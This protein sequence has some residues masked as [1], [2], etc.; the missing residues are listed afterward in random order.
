MTPAIPIVDVT[1]LFDAAPHARQAPDR[2][3]AAAARDIG[4]VC[5]CGLPPEAAPD[6]AARARLLA[7]FGLE[8]A[9][10]RRLYRRKFAPE[11]PNIYRGWF[12]LQPGNLTAKEGIDIGG[13]LVHGSAIAVRGD[14]LREPSPLPDERCLP[15]WRAAAAAYYRAMELVAQA[16]MCSLA[17]GL[18]LRSDYF[19]DSFRCG[20]STL[21]LIRYPPRDPAELATVQDPAVWAEVDGMRRYLVGAPHTDSG[22]VTLLAQD[23]VAGLQAR[24][25]SGQWV[26]VPPLEGTLVVNFGQVLEQWSAGRIRA[27][28]HRVLGSGRERFSIPFFYEARADARI[29]PLPLDRADLFT[30]FEYG[31]FLWQRMTS[32]IEFRGMERERGRY[33]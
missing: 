22:F 17:R 10:K 14:P 31:D 9:G 29:A 8:E 33:V 3:L 32:F 25:R 23:G 21:R 26:D 7:V 27:T 11:N 1:P 30:P 15:G 19:D 20:L 28:E 24:S 4:F 5:V 2:A 18:G 12:P 13:D 16:V 6:P